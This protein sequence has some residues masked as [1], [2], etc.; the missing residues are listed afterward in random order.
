[1]HENLHFR[2]FFFS[3][4]D[5]FC[6]KPLN[7]C[8]LLGLGGESLKQQQNSMKSMISHLAIISFMEEQDSAD[9]K[10]G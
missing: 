2:F 7:N 3:T 10:A 8:C 9:S 6:S 5:A 4:K 1:M